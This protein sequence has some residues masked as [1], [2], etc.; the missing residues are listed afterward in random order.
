MHEDG[1]QFAI[2]IISKGIDTIE[3]RSYNFKLVIVEVIEER[4][5]SFAK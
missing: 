2:A 3:F 5:I 4:D 1:M